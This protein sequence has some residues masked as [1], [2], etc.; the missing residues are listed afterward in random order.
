MSIPTDADLPVTE[1]QLVEALAN[2]N[3]IGVA[4]NR[5]S[6]SV[7]SAAEAVQATLRLIAESAI[8]VTPGASAVI[9]AY[10][11]TRRAFDLASRVSAG[12]PPG[13]PL[14]DAPRP[15]GIGIAALSQRRRVLSY[16][17]PDMTIHPAKVQAGAKTMACF[18]L[19]VANQAVG[20]LYVYLHQERPFRQFELLLLDN[21][22]NQ[23]AMAI[24]QARQLANVRRDLQRRE[25]EL[26]RLGRAG[27]LISS[28]MGLEE[29]LESILQMALEVTQAHYG[30]FRLVDESGA[31]LITRAMAGAP[32][33]RP[34]VEPL[35]IGATSI[36]GW[37]A[38]H[39][40]PLCIHD[41]QAA[42][43]NRLYYPLDSTLHMRAELAVPLI[44]SGGRLEGVLNLESPV[45]GMFDEADSLL[46][47]AL[48]TQAVIAIQEARL[49][50][51]LLEVARLLLVQPPPDVLHHLVGL[52]CNLLDVTA[53]AIWTLEGEQIALRAAS[54]DFTPAPLPD[55]LIA[56]AIRTG[57]P[58]KTATALIAP[59]LSSEDRKPIGAFGVYSAASNRS[60]VSEWDEKVLTCL[61]YYAALARHT[62]MRQQALRDAQERHAVA[63]TFAAMGDIAANVLHHLNNKVGAIPVRI[64]GI[65]DKCA[66]TL[67][68]DAYL[69]ANLAAIEHNA[70]E[71]MK[72]VRE[73]LAHLHPLHLAPVNVADC[74]AAALEATALPAGIHVDVTGLATLPPV[75]AGERSL[76]LVFTNLLENAGRA[77]QGHGHITLAGSATARHVEITVSDDGPGIPPAQH[78]HIFEFKNGA[79][80]QRAY[81]PGDRAASQLGFGLWWVKTL[82]VR[83]GGAI[84]V[85][86]DGVHG[87]TFRIRLP[88][89]EETQ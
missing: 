5:F 53:A 68:A 25:D 35:P 75:L 16:E 81:P 42:P 11:Q 20:A 62:A 65:Q 47:Q 83:L 63:E 55:R 74:V 24:Y 27:L 82:V 40:Q 28:R 57:A 58:L 89:A 18:P 29:T 61:A 86:S 4:I 17:E 37:V 69:A 49:L 32:L 84:T 14:H 36:M 48:A 22:V 21:F 6:V 56:E 26:N 30:A 34:H 51:A 78:Q 80:T 9:Y 66:D 44:G 85:A 67:R 31:T 43:W 8:K 87:A 15:H 64:Q 46:L 60:V 54:A 77:L 2:L 38:E 19:I 71:A 3:R 1:P 79:K 76:S 70:H 41:L 12:E 88:I 73:N 72:A 23:A 52:A 45:I 10:D 7:S 13:A 50:D 59:I 33:E 39:R